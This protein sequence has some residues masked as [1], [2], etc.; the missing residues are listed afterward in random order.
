MYAYDIVYGYMC[1]FIHVYEFIDMTNIEWHTYMFATLIRY[2]DV[3]KYVP[4]MIQ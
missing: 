3:F 1:K 4:L 2:V